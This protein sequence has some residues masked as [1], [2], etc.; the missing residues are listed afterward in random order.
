MAEQGHAP[1]QL[2]KLNNNCVPVN[3]LM[4]TA[5]ITAA[6][7]L[8]NWISPNGTLEILMSLVV[9]STVMNWML[10]SYTHLKFKRAKQAAGKSTSYNSPLFPL[11]NYLCIAFI[12]GLLA[13]MAF[14]PGM[15]ISV[16]LIPLWLSV[17]YASY[18][19]LQTM[20]PAELR[21]E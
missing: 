11:T 14:I 10:T 4:V 3:A 16:W 19:K 9:A 21:F 1:R 6:A 17:M 18:R 8:L 5:V 20:K 7:V 12:L 2:L 15:R 13:I